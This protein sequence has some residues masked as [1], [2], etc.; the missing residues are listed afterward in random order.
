ML[1][2]NKRVSERLFVGSWMLESVSSDPGK[3]DLYIALLQTL[4]VVEAVVSSPVLPNEGFGAFCFC[5]SIQ[6]GCRSLNVLGLS[7]IWY[8]VTFVAR[9]KS[10]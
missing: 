5:S 3:L 9:F 2:L 1:E 7:F 6:F 8:Y 10:I 4:V